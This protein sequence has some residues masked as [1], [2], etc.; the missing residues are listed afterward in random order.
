MLVVMQF[1]VGK[2]GNTTMDQWL[3]QTDI[4]GEVGDAAHITA[5]KDPAG[6]T[7]S[8]VPEKLNPADPKIQAQY[9]SM[10]KHWAERK[11]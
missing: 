9:D 3:F 2:D 5:V 8:A 6:K 1:N 4:Y 11:P 10:L 7:L